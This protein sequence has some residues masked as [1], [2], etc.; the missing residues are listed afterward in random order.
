MFVL[1]RK[2]T[3]WTLRL[4]TEIALLFICKW[5]SYLTGNT[6][7][8][9]ITR[10]ALLYICRIYS[11][12]TENTRTGFHGLLR[13]QLYLYFTFTLTPTTSWHVTE[14]CKCFVAPHKFA[15]RSS[16]LVSAARCPCL[17][18][19]KSEQWND[20]SGICL[21]LVQNCG[22]G[23]RPWTM[24]AVL[25]QRA[26]VPT[27]LC[28]AIFVNDSLFLLLPPLITV[29]LLCHLPASRQVRFYVCRRRQVITEVNIPVV[30][31]RRLGCYTV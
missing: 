22:P 10:I 28:H 11:Y 12:L 4:V 19:W 1:H 23:Y 3:Y 25:W 15:S 13:G 29:G 31:C 30:E 8:L 6:S 5:C 27:C 24:A 20:V 2:H 26:Q 16:V 14:R 17:H 9:P 18:P 7:P 21:A